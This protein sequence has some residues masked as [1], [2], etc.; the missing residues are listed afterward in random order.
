M[1]RLLLGLVG[2]LVAS[3][4]FAQEGNPARNYDFKPPLYTAVDV[5]TKPWFS[6]WSGDCNSGRAPRSIML[7]RID[8]ATRRLT[9]VPVTVSWGA[10]PDAAAYLAAVCT[11]PF[12]ENVGWSVV[13]TE[14][15]PAG[16]FTYVV[17]V[18]DMPTAWTCGVYP[19]NFPNAGQQWCDYVA[20]TVYRIVQ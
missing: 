12:D 14:P 11:R 2:L 9:N 17:Y 16:T 19:A 5:A 20:N 3:S 18:T 1:K 15:E 4:A 8:L 7:W 13:P 10:R 6:G